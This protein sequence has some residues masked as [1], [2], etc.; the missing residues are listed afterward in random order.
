MVRKH[1]VRDR[2]IR[3]VAGALGIFYIV[4]GRRDLGP[5]PAERLWG[6]GQASCVLSSWHPGSIFSLGSQSII[7]V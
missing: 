1:E 7:P 2:L 3:V 4:R 5:L 6:W